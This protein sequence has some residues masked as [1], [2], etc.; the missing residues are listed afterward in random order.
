MIEWYE[1]IAMHWWPKKSPLMPSYFFRKYTNRKKNIFTK[2]GGILK[3]YQPFVPQLEF[4]SQGVSTELEA[5]M[6][7]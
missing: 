5:S 4:A 3:K 7:V 1:D 2:Q 6:C